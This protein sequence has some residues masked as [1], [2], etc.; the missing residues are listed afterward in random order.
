MTLRFT[1]S[2]DGVP[3]ASV[4]IDFRVDLGLLAV[5]A[6]ELV[7]S[8]LVEYVGAS[9]E[10]AADAE[11]YAAALGRGRI[12]QSARD[13]LQ[14]KGYTARDAV[15]DY[16]MEAALTAVAP[17]VAELWPQAVTT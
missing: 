7:F 6:A 10:V 9:D 5:A 3:R 17:V 11:E 2:K 15:E 4:R 1:E 12:V 14:A 16:L 8:D 13:L